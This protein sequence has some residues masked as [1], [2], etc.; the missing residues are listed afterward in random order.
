MVIDSIFVYHFVDVDLRFEIFFEK[1]GT[2]GNGGVDF[3]IGDIGTLAHL[4]WR[5]KNISYTTCLLFYCFFG[6]KK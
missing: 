3:E 5:L 1:E 4:H 6:D 2:A